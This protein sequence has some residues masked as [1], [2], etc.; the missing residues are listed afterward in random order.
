[1]RTIKF[2]N[3]YRGLVALSKRATPVD[4]LKEELLILQDGDLIPPRHVANWIFG[5]G[6]G[7]EGYTWKP[8]Q[9]DEEEWKEIVAAFEAKRCRTTDPPAWVRT[10]A[11]WNAWVREIQFGI[12][13]MQELRYMAGDE[14]YREQIREALDAGDEELA[15]HLHWRRVSGAEM[16][17]ELDTYAAAL[18]GIRKGLAIFARSDDDGE[19]GDEE[20]DGDEP[21]SSKWN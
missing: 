12:P 21:E 20:G 9:V 6:R 16:I 7:G 13:A 10:G 17:E 11:D 4:L 3:L 2:K 15:R 1:M 18:G 19:D 14:W 5:L 8:F